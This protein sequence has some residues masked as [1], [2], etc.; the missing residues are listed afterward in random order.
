MSDAVTNHFVKADI[1]E[2]SP[3]YIKRYVKEALSDDLL[4]QAVLKATATAVTKRQERVDETPYWEL[5]RQRARSYKKEIVDHLGWY[6]DSFARHCEEGGITVHWAADGEEARNIILDIARKNNVKKVVKSKSLTSEEIGLNTALLAEGID[7]IETDLGEYIVQLQGKI[8]S[9]LTMPAL[10]LS[11]QDI[12]RI[13]EKKLG[14]AYTDDPNELLGIA[15]ARLR[16]HFL[17]ADMGIT[18]VNFGLAEE[19][20]LCLIENEANAHL[21]L[22]LP[23]VQVALMGLEKM[24][25]GLEALPVFLKLLAPSATGQR[26]SSYVNFIGGPTRKLLGEGPEEVHLVLLDNGRSRIAKDPVLRETLHCMRCGACLN[27]CPVYQQIGGHA[28]GW[29]YMGPIGSTLIP[30]YLGED[31]GR[32]GPFLCSLCCACRDTC[33]V[34]IDLP[35]HLLDLRNRVVE[36]GKSMLLER[37]G[38]RGWALLARHP[39]L[40][41]LATW[42]PGKAQQL[43]PRGAAFPAPGYTRERALGRF[44]VRGFRKRFIRERSVRQKNKNSQSSPSSGERNDNE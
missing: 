11:R 6:L 14:V 36:A 41:R 28:Y 27:I 1:M 5:L 16:Q 17:S 42:F 37:L 21:S 31:E 34:M 33:P 12:G 25:P 43:L 30:Q 22:S 10:H 24:I 38:I 7:A 8:P 26:S 13:F 15:R 44:D 40:Y 4:R 23:R 35:S 32:Y 19:G 39:L 29:V 3:K 2:V 18:G 9:H 20:C